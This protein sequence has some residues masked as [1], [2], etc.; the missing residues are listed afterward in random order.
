MTRSPRGAL[1]RC[2]IWST[3]SRT[4]VRLI[5]C[6]LSGQARRCGPLLRDERA[7]LEQRHGLGRLGSRCSPGAKW[8]LGSIDVSGALR[9]G[10]IKLAVV[11]LVFDSQRRD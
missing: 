7:G 11:P 3:E 9:H 6:I 2:W 4:A 8:R 5:V 10:L 1:G